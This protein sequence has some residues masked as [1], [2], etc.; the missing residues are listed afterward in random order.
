MLKCLQVLLKKLKTHFCQTFDGTLG[1]V[2]C[3]YIP[4]NVIYPLGDGVVIIEDGHFENNNM[5]II[6]LEYIRQSYSGRNE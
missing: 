4:L 3:E 1:H 6:L 2:R 5:E